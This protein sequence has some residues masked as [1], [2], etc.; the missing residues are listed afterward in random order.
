MLFGSEPKGLR[1]DIL[2]KIGTGLLQFQWE[3]EEEA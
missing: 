2:L 1:E 3:R